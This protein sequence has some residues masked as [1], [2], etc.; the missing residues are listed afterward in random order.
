M[1]NDTNHFEEFEDPKEFLNLDIKNLFSEI[2]FK[3]KL[4]FQYLS[5]YNPNKYVQLLL[6]IASITSTLDRSFSKTTIF[7]DSGI[8]YFIGGLLGG[9]LVTYALYYILAW[10]LY[11][12]GKAFLNGQA[13]SKDFRMV[14]AWSRVPAIASIVFSLY[15][16]SF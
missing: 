15:Q 6:I 13:S 5:N 3:P 16:F 14:I 2:W 4:V 11:Y 12:Y 1:N 8:E 7:K 9:A 10:F